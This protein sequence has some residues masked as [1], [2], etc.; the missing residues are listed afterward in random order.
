MFKLFH[1]LCWINY[2]KL[3]INYVITRANTNGTCV[4]HMCTFNR[5]LM[6]SSV[7]LQSIVVIQRKSWMFYIC[8]SQIIIYIISV[9]ECSE[10]LF[11]F[12]F[13]KLANFTAWL[14]QNTMIWSSLN[15]LN[16]RF[17]HLCQLFLF[18]SHTHYLYF[19]CN[20]ICHW[21]LQK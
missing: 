21:W 7:M 15:S 18:N 8:S 2:V 6:F 12:F 13:I 5:L 4:L 20:W 3:I 9:M 1:L 10:I 11:I 14:V 17:S 19:C 16:W